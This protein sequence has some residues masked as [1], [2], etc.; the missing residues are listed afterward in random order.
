MIFLEITKLMIFYFFGWKKSKLEE[1]SKMAIYSL[2]PN[3]NHPLALCDV[4]RYSVLFI[5][6]V[7]NGQAGQNKII[8][9][10]KFKN[11]FIKSKLLAK[12]HWKVTYTFSIKL[13]LTQSLA[14][15]I[16]KNIQI[17]NNVRISN[18]D[19]DKNWFLTGRIFNMFNF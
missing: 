17:K 4:D 5:L 18:F 8:N 9:F 7:Q 10:Q 14:L 12:Y 19:C 13:W 15:K 2:V 16:S 3:I 11:T 6:C 1:N